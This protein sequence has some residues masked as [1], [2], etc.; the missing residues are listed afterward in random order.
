MEKIIDHERLR[1][2]DFEAC[3]L[4]EDSWPIEIGISS[5]IRQETG[6]SVNTWSSL[7]RPHETWNMR[8][9][10]KKSQS[11]HGIT[12]ADLNSAPDACT[13]AHQVRDMLSGCYV[14][15]D[16]PQYDGYWLRTLL[17][18]NGPVPRLSMNHFQSC[19]ITLFDDAPLDMLFEKLERTKAPHRAGPDSAR[20]ASSWAYALQYAPGDPPRP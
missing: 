12:R 2:I 11:V 4:N 5:L 17:S 13:V 16:S 3:S 8:S 14:V 20:L 7:I 19:A 1:F 18:V 9:W 6:V 15:C 10:S